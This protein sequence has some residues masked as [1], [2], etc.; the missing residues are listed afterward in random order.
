[1]VNAP[2]GRIPTKLFAS[3]PG[4]DTFKREQEMLGYQFERNLSDDVTFRQNARFAHVDVTLS[5]LFG[6]GYINNGPATA[7]LS[8]GYF[9]THGIANQ[10]NLDNQLEYRFN[11]GILQHTALFGLD[12]KHYRIDDWQIFAFGGV[13]SINAVQSG[14]WLGDTPFTGSTPS[15]STLTQKQLGFYAAG[16][17]Q[18]RR[19]YAGAERPQ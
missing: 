14:L 10:G 19:L 7:T 17:D 8:R 4:V 6:L 15:G 16:P 12:L 5:T 13:P 18:A 3:D 2:F 11:T 1:M 9:L